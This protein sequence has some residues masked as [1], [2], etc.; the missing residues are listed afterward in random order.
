MKPSS[1]VFFCAV[2]R[3]D[4]VERKYPGGVARYLAEQGGIAGGNLI[5][6]STMASWEMNDWLDC[7]EKDHKLL[8]GEDIALG[9]QFHGEVESCPGVVFIAPNRP[10]GGWT[11]KFEEST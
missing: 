2:L 9:E 7:M 1:I 11:V 5:L 8:V 10:M 6:R 4:A 3:A